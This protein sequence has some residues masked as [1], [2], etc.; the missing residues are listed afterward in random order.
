MANFLADLWNKV[1]TF[2]SGASS[3]VH[4]I[5]TI[6]DNVA[7][8]IK[9]LEATDVGQFLEVTIETIIPSST[10]LVNAFKLWLPK[11]VTDLNWAVQEEGKTDAQKISDAVTYLTNLKA[12]NPDAYASQL[13]S[14]NAL[15]QKWLSDNQ[16][17]GLNIQ[18]ALTISQVNHNPNLVSAQ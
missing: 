15:I 9:K 18:Q 12:S 17:A 8:E 13:N 6:A 16:G 1:K 5:I 7:N 3:E 2:F 4:T 14:I 10:G 11:I